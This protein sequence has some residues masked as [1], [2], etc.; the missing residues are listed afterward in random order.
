MQLAL[1]AVLAGVMLAVI[2]AGQAW[3]TVSA[4]VE[5][6][7]VGSARLGA[8]E[9]TGNDLAP[10]G[11][12]ALGGLVL[13]V[14]VAATRGRGR[15]VVGVALLALGGRPGRGGRGRRAGGVATEA[16]ERAELGLLEGVPAGTGLQVDTPGPARSWSWPAGCCWPPPGSR[17]CGAGAAGRRSVTRSAPRPT[18]P[19]QP[20]ARTSRHGRATDQDLY[21]ARTCPAE[22]PEPAPAMLASARR[23]KGTG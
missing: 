7:G 12:L 20:L 14:A 5:L 21:R 13:L 4:A 9:I 11:A 10:L 2:G 16:V 17:R 3:A 18:A 15:W 23:R 1:V 19:S 6:P 22:R 8:A